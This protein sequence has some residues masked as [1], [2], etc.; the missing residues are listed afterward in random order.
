MGGNITKE[1]LFGLWSLAA[2]GSDLSPAMGS[3]SWNPH[4][5][6]M[7]QPLNKPVWKCLKTYPYH[8]TQ[9]FCSRQL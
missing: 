9:Q 3:S 5:P 8:M 1:W 2:L 7:V 4:T 6:L